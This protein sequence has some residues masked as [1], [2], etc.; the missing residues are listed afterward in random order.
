MCGMETDALD[1]AELSDGGGTESADG[2]AGA[3]QKGT[4]LFNPHHYKFEWSAM[5]LDHWLSADIPA[6]GRLPKSPSSCP[7][8]PPVPLIAS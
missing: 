2:G 3:V 1:T 6:G 5:E 8:S 4:W 7:S